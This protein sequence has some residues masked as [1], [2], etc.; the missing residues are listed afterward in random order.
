MDSWGKGYRCLYFQLLNFHWYLYVRHRH[1][2]LD[3]ITN[4]LDTTEQKDLWTRPEW[5]W[6]SGFGRKLLRGCQQAVKKS[7]QW[8]AFPRGAQTSFLFWSIWTG[9]SP[10]FD[11]VDFEHHLG[12]KKKKWGKW[13][14]VV[15][16]L[17]NISRWKHFTTYKNKRK[18]RWGSTI[19]NNFLWM[20]RVVWIRFGVKMFHT[21]VTF[22]AGSFSRI[23]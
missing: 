19:K 16:S 4:M 2:D 11:E 14:D 3:Q 20:Q 10:T 18:S 17:E 5:Y 15:Q 8:A 9:G 12:K 21:V 23:Y 7:E 13:W 6:F 1:T 22:R